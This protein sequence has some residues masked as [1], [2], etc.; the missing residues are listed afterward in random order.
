MNTRTMHEDLG[1]ETE[2]RSGT[3]R[4][5][6]VLMAI[7]ASIVTGVLTIINSPKTVSLD[8]Q[9]WECTATEPSGI[10]ARC[11]NFTMKK[12]GLRTP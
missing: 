8:S 9:H 3:F 12:F 6:M 7:A 1:M 10:E 2:T 4:R 5:V 11:T